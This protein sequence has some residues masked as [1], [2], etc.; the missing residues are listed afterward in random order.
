MIVSAQF[1]LGGFY[2]RGD[3]LA[4]GAA[5]VARSACS[6]N[7]SPTVGALS[8][9]LTNDVVCL[10]VAP[11]LI[12]V[13]LRRRQLDPVPFLLGLAC[14]GQRRQAATLIGN[15]Q[16]MLI[17]QALQLSFA[18]YLLDGGVPAAARPRHRL[19]GARPRLPRPLRTRPRADGDGGRTVR[20]RPDG[21]RPRGSAPCWSRACFCRPLPREVQAM[22]A[23]AALLVS[24]RRVASRQLL[25]PRRLAAARVVRGPVRLST[26]PSRRPA[27]PTRPSAGCAHDGLDLSDPAALFATSVLGSNLVSNVPLTMLLLPVAEHPKAG[28]ILCARDHAGGQPAA[29]RFDREPD[30]RRTGTPPRRAPVGT[31]LGL[32]APADRGADRPVD[33]AGGRR[34]ALAP[35]L[36]QGKP[37]Q[38]GPRLPRRHRAGCIH[39]CRCPDPRPAR[40]A[41]RGRGLDGAR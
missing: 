28:P 38:A 23:A 31:Q 2:G 7:W 19:V 25:D 10:A 21:Q 6:P 12:D 9:V 36:S 15:P 13:C 22:L 24:R 27:M 14:R 18:R 35:Q 4:R 34:L 29:G 33:P 20:P 11:V 30:R 1:Q 16:N 26:M 39:A 40:R 37:V 32:R 8:A 41:C 3:A 5:D 17:G